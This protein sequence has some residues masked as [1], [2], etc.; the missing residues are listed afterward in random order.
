[1]AKTGGKRSLDSFT[2]QGTNKVVKGIIYT[3]QK[4]SFV[5]LAAFDG[6]NVGVLFIIGWVSIVDVISFSLVLGFFL[7]T[8]M[9]KN[10]FFFFIF[11]YFFRNDAYSNDVFFLVCKAQEMNICDD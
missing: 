7:F 8:C 10:H 3:S 2:I 6:R 4:F 5:F 11:R 1:M 9:Y